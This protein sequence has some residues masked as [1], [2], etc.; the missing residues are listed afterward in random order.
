MMLQKQNKNFL[1]RILVMEKEILGNGE[2]QRN[3]KEYG[4][5]VNE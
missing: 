3:E 1:R 2:L 5:E 4:G